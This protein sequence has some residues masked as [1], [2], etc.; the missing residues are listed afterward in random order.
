MM[1]SIA[2]VYT[3]HGPAKYQVSYTKF[4]RLAPGIYFALMY[5]AKGLKDGQLFSHIFKM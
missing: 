2:S 1:N 4:L 5:K 3:L